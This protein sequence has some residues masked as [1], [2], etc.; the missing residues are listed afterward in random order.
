[1]KSWNYWVEIADEDFHLF[2][3]WT[4]GSLCSET[5]KRIIGVKAYIENDIARLAEKN[6]PGI[7]YGTIIKIQNKVSK[8]QTELEDE[9]LGRS[10]FKNCIEE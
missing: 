6:I 7:S 3:K 9:F 1:M 5:G 8:E 4:N 2:S 10:N